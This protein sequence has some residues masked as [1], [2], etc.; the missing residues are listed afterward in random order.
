[1]LNW[2]TN[3]RVRVQCTT[4]YITGKATTSLLNP[5]IC[6]THAMHAFT[7]K[8]SGRPSHESTLMLLRFSSLSLASLSLSCCKLASTSVVFSPSSSKIL[9]SAYLAMPCQST[10]SARRSSHSNVKDYSQQTSGYVIIRQSNR[11]DRWYFLSS[12]RPPFQVSRCPC[13]W[14]DKMGL[15]G[16]LKQ[17]DLMPFLVPRIQIK[18]NICKAP[19]EWTFHS[20]E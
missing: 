6:N 8:L 5:C 9:K 2:T 13:V 20:S 7:E 17:S 11:E 1:M 3:A 16:A 19:L 15:R 14:W 10:R 18:S 12:C 4:K